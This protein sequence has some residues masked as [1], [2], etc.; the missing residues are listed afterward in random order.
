M[1]INLRSARKLRFECHRP[2]HGTASKHEPRLSPK[3]WNW[4]RWFP[5]VFS[6]MMLSCIFDTS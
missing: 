3:L 4:W 2:L 1:S 6:V 5:S